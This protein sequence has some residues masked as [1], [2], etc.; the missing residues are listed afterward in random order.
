VKLL[1]SIIIVGALAASA[2]AQDATLKE[3]ATH[4]GLNYEYDKFDDFDSVNALL[5]SGLMNF[6]Y[7]GYVSKEHHFMVI[8]RASEIMYDDNAI[9]MV[10]GQ[11]FKITPL[12][13]HYRSFGTVVER[14]LLS[15]M[16]ANPGRCA[17]KVGSFEYEFTA[18]EV[19][20]IKKLLN[21]VDGVD[22][23]SVAKLY[24]PQVLIEQVPLQAIP[25]RVQIA[26]GVYKTYTRT[27]Y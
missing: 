18:G 9:F 2:S 8:I 13:R 27:D 5:N 10:D 26:P 6:S 4:A 24:L 3:R 20:K 12:V 19:A 1:F 23:G 16:I 11:R 17:V 7:A 25:L 15:R 21:V 14:D 22:S